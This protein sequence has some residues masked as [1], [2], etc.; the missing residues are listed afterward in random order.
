[1]RH[2]T[3][4]PKVKSQLSSLQLFVA[5]GA[6]SLT[7]LTGCSAAE[8]PAESSAEPE[9]DRAVAQVNET[10]A[11]LVPQDI[12]DAGTLQMA[13]TIGMAPLGYPDQQSGELVGFNVDI[14]NQ[15]GE[16]L[17]LDV[18]V[19]GVS[20]DQ[21][22]PGM[23]A[24]RYDLTASNMAIT[25]ARQEVLDFV[26]YYFGASSLAFPTG[27][28]K[29]LSPDNLCGSSV[30]VSIGSFQQTEVMPGLSEACEEAGSD[31]ID[32]QEFPDQQKA[33][34]AMNSGRI[35]AVAADS[36][37]LHYAAGQ[38][39]QVEVGENLTAGSVLGI[40]LPEGSPMV[41]AV[42]AAMNDLIETGIYQETLE[43]Y[44]IVDLGI[45]QSEI[46]K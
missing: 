2:T 17:G 18:E 20:L 13:T 11:A 45:E 36:A 14:M 9:R 8:S 38:N 7:V 23:Q 34:L 46:K 22:I 6:I 42:H 10:A 40:G 41:E 30:G 29:G 28:P 19:H 31:A 16:V 43:S 44:G 26:E 3:E 37:I 21:I 15:V 32:I 33:I 12:A 4:R 1:M 25:D 5:T 39:D 24:G 27:N 35:D